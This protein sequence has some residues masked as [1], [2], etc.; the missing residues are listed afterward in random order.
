MHKVTYFPSIFKGFSDEYGGRN[1][2][3]RVHF[4]FLLTLFF[5]NIENKS[6]AV[7]T[8]TFSKEDKYSGFACAPSPGVS[9]NVISPCAP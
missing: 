5:K 8:R 9:G 2:N 4:I 7:Y 3:T 1:Q 6:F